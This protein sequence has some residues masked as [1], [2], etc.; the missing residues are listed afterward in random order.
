MTIKQK[1]GLPY[2]G[3]SRFNGQKSSRMETL[4]EEN[5]QIKQ[6]I[7]ELEAVC[8]RL[9]TESREKDALIA[10]LKLEKIQSIAAM[11]TQEKELFDAI[12]D[13]SRLTEAHRQA[14]RVM[15]GSIKR[16]IKHCFG[17][18]NF[19]LKQKILVAEEKCQQTEKRMKTVKD[20]LGSI[21]TQLKEENTK[22]HNQ[23]TQA[24][25][26]LRST[27]KK[28]MQISEAHKQALNR[29][30]MSFG[31]SV[32]NFLGQKLGLDQA[33]KVLFERERLRIEKEK[34]DHE[35]FCLEREREIQAKKIAKGEE[36]CCVVC[37]DE[38][39]DVDMTFVPCGHNICCRECSNR[40]KICPACRQPIQKYIKTFH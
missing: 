14:M 40:L 13:L 35:Q 27:E 9:R 16:S 20:E 24:Q 12:L 3:N 30:H 21:K 39:Q 31:G 23:L 7:V 4:E 26:R 25:S 33:D 29:L 19:G 22:A 37:L 8:E 2:S 38:E 32:R 6:K 15:K 28:L 5:R 1:P 34:L 36:K 10:R 17:K 18:E 11:E